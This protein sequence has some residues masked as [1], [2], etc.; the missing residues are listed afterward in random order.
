[1]LSLRNFVVSP[2]NR[3]GEQRVYARLSDGTLRR[4]T[5]PAIVNRVLLRHATQ[6]DEASD[7]W[8]RRSLRFLSRNR[9]KFITPVIALFLLWLTNVLGLQMF[10]S[11]F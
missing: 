4:I 11:P 1:M 3:P 6:Q 5:D 9:W 8:V 7:G 2:G 10:E